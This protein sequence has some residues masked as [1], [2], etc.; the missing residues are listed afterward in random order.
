LSPD[1][2]RLRISAMSWSSNSDW[3]ML[4]LIPGPRIRCLSGQ[5]SVRT[6]VLLY[7]LR[8]KKRP[9]KTFPR[10]TLPGN[11]EAPRN[12][13]PR[14]GL[15]ATNASGTMPRVHQLNPFPG[16]AEKPPISAAVPGS[17]N[18]S[19]FRHAMPCTRMPYVLAESCLRLQVRTKRTEIGGRIRTIFETVATKASGPY[20]PPASARCGSQFTLAPSPAG[21][22]TSRRWG[23]CLRSWSARA[24]E[25]N[26]QMIWFRTRR[27]HSRRV[28]QGR[29]CWGRF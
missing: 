25:R 28:A 27:T 6:Q 19:V 9:Q 12:R 4:L 17:G 18:S 13:T 20:G 11:G 26:V 10:C 3:P 22:I 8:S 5:C 1:R 23:P 21:N 16:Q 7:P 24:D 2:Q 29:V 15:G 14:S